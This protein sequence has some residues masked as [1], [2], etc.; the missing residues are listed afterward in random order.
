MLQTEV[1]A[2]F[3]PPDKSEHF[4]NPAENDA[5]FELSLPSKKTKEDS[6][7]K[8]RGVEALYA[9]G[10]WYKSW[11]SSLLENGS[12]NFM[13]TTKR[14]KQISNDYTNFQTDNFV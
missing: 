3:G 8:R 14:Q 9:N 13:M 2:K 7:E 1:L 11:L 12:S 10:V 6:Y 5:D 4:S